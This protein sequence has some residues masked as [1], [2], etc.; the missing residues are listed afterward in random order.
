MDGFNLIHDFLS[1]EEN[2]QL[3]EFLDE[4]SGYSPEETSHRHALG[5]PGFRV[6]SKISMD[7]PAL[8]LTGDPKKDSA[9]M[10]I[11]EIYDRVKYFLQDVYKKELLLIQA[12]YTEIG[13]GP[14]MGLHSDN[15]WLDG[16]IRDDDISIVMEHSAVLYLNSHGEEFTGGGLYFPLQDYRYLPRERDL[17]YFIGDLDHIHIVEAV[18]SGKRKSLSIFYGDKETVI[19]HRDGA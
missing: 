9:I 4:V 14:G 3:V 10:L 1:E 16:E 6:A 15:Y 2:N 11:T 17:A 12:S 19:K 7:N 8:P 13:V 18:E 5:Y